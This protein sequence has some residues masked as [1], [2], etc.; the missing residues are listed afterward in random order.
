MR[1]EVEEIVDQ[2]HLAFGAVAIGNAPS[3]ASGVQGLVDF[4]RQQWTNAPDAL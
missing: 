3:S 1:R 4:R 2:R